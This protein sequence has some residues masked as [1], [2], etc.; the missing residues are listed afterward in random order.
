MSLLEFFL[1][2]DIGDTV[3]VNILL[4]LVGLGEKDKR[5]VSGV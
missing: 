5:L 3:A 2:G 4:S 1:F